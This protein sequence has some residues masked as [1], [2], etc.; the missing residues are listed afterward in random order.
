M[1][2][3]TAILVC[4]LV[5]I[6]PALVS[7]TTISQWTFENNTPTD[8][9]NSKNG[10]NVTDESGNANGTASG[11]HASD[12]TDWSTPGGNGSANSFSANTWAVGDYWQFS[13]STL[14]YQDITLTWDQY[15]SSTAP[16]AWD[17]AYSLNGVNFTV[18]L[19]N[20][21]PST[22][23]WSSGSTIAGAGL[24]VNLMAV[25]DLDNA[26]TVFFR[27]IADS[28]A[29]NS[30]GT[31]RIDNFTVNGTGISTNVPDSIPSF[32][33]LG[34]VLAVLVSLRRMTR[35]NNLTQRGVA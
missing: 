13:V 31:S 3:S 11:Y 28:S 27:I 1:K 32:A 19:D 21:A 9:N 29:S 34:C 24:S 2:T 35:F 14:G 5:G 15:R 10:P 6:T 30:S 25:S 4:S 8:L 7:G 12:Q 33:G 20:Y 16:A 22:S 26:S 17:F 18:A 23:T